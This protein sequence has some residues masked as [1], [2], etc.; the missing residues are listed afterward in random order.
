MKEMRKL[1]KDA[2]RWSADRKRAWRTY[3]GVVRERISLHAAAAIAT[4]LRE[5]RRTS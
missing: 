5:S 4:F 1:D 2:C 3:N